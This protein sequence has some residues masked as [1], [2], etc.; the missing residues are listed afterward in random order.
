MT[1]IL[2]I[3]RSAW[4]FFFFLPLQ[5]MAQTRQADSL[6][7]LAQSATGS[8]KVRLYIELVS[9]LRHNNPDTASYFAHQA[10]EL[11]EKSGNTLDRM[12][13][14][15]SLG[16]VSAVRGNSILAIKYFRQTFEL[17]TQENSDS[18]M[19][20]SLNGIATANWQLGK[21]ALALED[22]FKALKIRE[23]LQDKKGIAISMV[24]IGNVYQTQEKLSMA[25]KYIRDGLELMKTINIDEPALLMEAM[26]TLANN[27]GMQGKI[28]EAFALDEEGI[29]IAE[30]T[31]NEFVKAM[32]YDNMG[33]CYLYGSPPDYARAIEYFTKTL[34]IDSAFSNKKQMSDSYSNLGGVFFEQKKYGDAIP[35]LQRSIV[36]AEESGFTQGKLRSLSMLA[37]AYRE[38]GQHAE[39]FR[40]LQ[41]TM[42]V[43]DSLVNTTSEARIAEL[44]TVYETEKQQ[45]QIDLQQ[46]QLSRK[47]SIIIGIIVALILLLLL[48]VSAWRRYRLKQA[49]KLQEEM[50]KQQEL[51]SQSIIKAE[52]NE[53]QRIAQ[54]LH[55]GLGQMM[56]AAKMNLS[57]FESGLHFETRE[58][59]QSFEKIIG[60]VDESCKEIRNISHNMMPN[61]LLKNNLA[62]ALRDFTDKIE[63]NSLQIH[64]YTEGLDQRLDAN[65]ETVLYRIIQ[66][67]VNNVIKHAEATSLDISVIKD[68]EGISAT[69]EDNGKG[70]SIDN[71]ENFEGI[72]LKNIKTR[73]VYLKGNI[74]IYSTIHRGTLIA[75]KVPFRS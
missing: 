29:A 32:F 35:Y 70:F 74:E 68:N 64:L 73:V 34:R 48:G 44:Q 16:R 3:Q 69:I 63:K 67:C 43:K 31:N 6:Y 27:Y 18:I 41:Q 33:N 20:M 26:H 56:S 75:I 59:K 22:H 42:K 25:E 24:N 4:L 11:A 49:T 46:A 37:T 52:E 19:A 71:K 54:D 28:K 14:Y 45:Q 9:T 13:V 40:T 10:A 65:L 15:Y 12:M 21:Y 55:D 47:N 8:N 30:R 7:R 1:V 60:L 58:Q 51:A 61:A 62:T 57:A 17:A 66:E 23:K 53:R 5:L 50:I 36:L 39:A 2:L 72:G 38:S